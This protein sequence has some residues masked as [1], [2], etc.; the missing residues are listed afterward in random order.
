MKKESW[1]IIAN[2]G[3]MKLF[4]FPSDS[5]KLTEADTVY[6][7]ERHKRA[8]DVNTDKEGSSQQSMG[9]QSSAYERHMDLRKIEQESFADQI[10][11]FLNDAALNHEYDRLYLAISKEFS[12]ILKNKLSPAVHKRLAEE[13]HKDLVHEKLHAIWDH[14]P[15]MK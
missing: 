13:T 1:L 7:E 3:C 12:G 15:S 14:F 10:A 11:K 9:S 8:H 5:K 6:N 4:R 2:S